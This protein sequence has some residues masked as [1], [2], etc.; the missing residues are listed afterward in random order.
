MLTK[1]RDPGILRVYSW[2]KCIWLYHYI[3]SDVNLCFIYIF[4]G[5][6]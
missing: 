6:I 3:L 1:K 4:L 5:I 2:N